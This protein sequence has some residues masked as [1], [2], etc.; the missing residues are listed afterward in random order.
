[1][2]PVPGKKEMS[3]QRVTLVVVFFL[4][5]AFWL[6]G[7]SSKA[8]AGVT[9]P[10]P[11]WMETI[12][13]ADEMMI[14]GIPSKVRQFTV[15][16]QVEEVLAFYR[17]QWEQGQDGMPGFAEAAAP[18]W[19]VISMVEQKRYLLTVQIKSKDGFSSTGYLAVGDLKN[20]RSPKQ[21]TPIPMLQG[22]RLVNDTTSR[23]P[24]Q[25]GRTSLVI[26]ESSIDANS[27]FYRNYYADRNWATVMDKAQEKGQVMFF[28]KGRKEVQ[29]VVNELFGSTRVVINQV[30]HD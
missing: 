26:S 13:V 21:R 29:V 8:L 19:Q 4:V 10:T 22:G 11:P 24:G 16:R 5:C 3:Q 17:L 14:N 20:F 23:D 27:T 30:S 1:M 15:D 12:S 7:L 2:L 6:A 9:I 25:K 28:R 18:P